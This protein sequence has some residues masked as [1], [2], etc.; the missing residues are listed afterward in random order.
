[1]ST[2]LQHALAPAGPQAAHIADLW[3]ITV[4][5]CGIVFVAVLVAVAWALVRAP[6]VTSAAPPDVE[7]LHRD[8]RGMR[9]VVAA[10]VGVSAAGLLFLL[11]A[12]LFTDRALAQLPLHGALNVE[13]TAH[14]WW[15]AVRY[16]DP[17]PSRTF[18]AANEIHVPVGRP[19][20]I[21]L[22]SDDVI[23]SFWVPALHGKKDLI[24]G[25]TARFE[26]R[27][28]EPGVY[29]GQC[30]EF[31]G[32]QHAF[33]AFRVTAVPPDEFERWAERQRKPA[34]EPSDP[35][36]RR[37]KEL[38]TTGPC[39]MCHAV[40]GTTASARKAPDLTH[41]AS[42][43]TLAAGRIANDAQNL[44]AWIRDPHRF[45]PGVNMPPHHASDADIGA[46][47]AYLGTLR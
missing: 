43:V 19:V 5:I 7:A 4:A 46:L 36:A 27:A 10:A 18:H 13:I 23:H 12:S 29:R 40:Q 17:D 11:G 34:P 45:K 20:V 41:V 33:M 21:T 35:T 2:P 9:H 22:K 38:F 44:E 1:M 30:A 26:M 39:M 31:C 28:D 14:K 37:G 25:R 3:W 24:P 42:R 47:V 8:D 16:D 6:R 15:W 32:L